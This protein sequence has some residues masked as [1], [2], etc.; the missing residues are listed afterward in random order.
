MKIS[1]GMYVV[2]EASTGEQQCQH[3]QIQ[4]ADHAMTKN[5]DFEIDW[6]GKKLLRNRKSCWKIKKSRDEKLHCAEL[7][8][9]Y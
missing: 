3:L 4:N 2:A 9:K 6:K 8:R 5:L 1:N 7:D